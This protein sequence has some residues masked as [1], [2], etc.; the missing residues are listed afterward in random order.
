VNVTGI[1]IVFAT[2]LAAPGDT[3]PA[4]TIDIAMVAVQ[5]THE[6]RRTKLIDAKLDGVRAALASLNYDT[7]RPVRAQRMSTQYNRDCRF[8]ISDRYTLFVTPLS[9]DSKGGI[10]VRARIQER[11]VAGKKVMTRN[12]LNVTSTVA[13][14]T[15][16]N[17]CGPKLESGDLV[18]VLSVSE[19]EGSSSP[20]P[21]S[22]S[23]EEQRQAPAVPRQNSGT[24]PRSTFR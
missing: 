7:F 12:A 9:K 8:A 18:I 3:A 22:S 20:E 4:K 6:G 1:A 10:R 19:K 13:E 23:G 2:M 5:A 16:L 14:G 24:I 15:H 11:R 17:L 21:P